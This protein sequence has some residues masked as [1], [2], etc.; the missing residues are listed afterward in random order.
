M[1]NRGLDIMIKTSCAFWHAG[2]QICCYSK[3]YVRSVT[4]STRLKTL[5]QNSPH[6]MQL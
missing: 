5:S 2:E 4:T 6:E 1:F 3:Q